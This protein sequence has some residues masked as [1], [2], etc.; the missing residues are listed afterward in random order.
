[1]HTMKNIRILLI[2]ILAGA[3]FP[4]CEYLDRE[5][6]NQLTLEMVFNQRDRVEQWLAGLYSNIPEPYVG[7]INVTGFDLLAD[8]LTMNS[9]MELYFNTFKMRSNW[10]SQLGWE[11]NYWTVLPQRIR[12]ANIFIENVHPVTQLTAARVEEMKAEARFLIAYYYWLLLESYGPI[13]FNPGVVYTDFLNI[14]GMMLTQTPYDN[15]VNWIDAELQEL[16]QVLPALYGD[17]GYYGRATAVMCHAVRAR[18]LLFAASPLVNGNPDYAGHVNKNGVELFNSAYSE[19][20]WQRAAAA[21]STLIAVAEGAGHALYKEYLADKTT[22]D[23]FKS[24]QMVMFPWSNNSNTEA[25]F[26]RPASRS[27]STYTYVAYTEYESWSTP[28]GSNGAGNLGVVQALV[29]DFFMEDGRPTGKGFNDSEIATP[30]PLYSETG[31]STAIERRTNT[32]WNSVQQAPGGYETGI[33]TLPGTWNMYCHREPRFYA[34]VLYNNAWIRRG[35]Y[36]DRRIDLR[37]GQL[38]NPVQNEV[39]FPETGYLI[40]KKVHPEHTAG[41]TGQTHQQRY[42]II[43]RLAEAYLSYAEALNEYDPGNPDILRYVNEIRTRAGI[44]EYGSGGVPAPVGKER[45]REAIRRERRI[46]LNCE[47]VRYNDIRRWKIGEVVLNKPLVGMNAL[48]GTKASDNPDDPASFYV[49]TTFFDRKFKK[50]Y[51]WMPLYQ[52]YLEKNP[53][54]VQNPYWN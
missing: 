37:P 2:V 51:Y 52:T 5:P 17:N 14:E 36:G 29:D 25:L 8:D 30:S 32:L 11:A 3:L 49:R 48:K 7:N 22:L 50:E 6:D 31:F 42:S 12:E 15:I 20:K 13:P 34:S 9:K 1:M 47:G 10:S 18:M 33:I 24:Y 4:A 26:V 53:N 39:N 44:P 35:E 40:M 16:A 45:M 23:P 54:L 43:Y 28:R 27:H 19:T 41:P 21:C 46:E 38:D